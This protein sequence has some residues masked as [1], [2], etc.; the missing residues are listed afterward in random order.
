MSHAKVAGPCA[1]VGAGA[2]MLPVTGSNTLAIALVA[3]SLIVS[4]L[5]LVRA[6]RFRPQG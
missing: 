5:L 1:A 3:M 4:G 2:A 6:A